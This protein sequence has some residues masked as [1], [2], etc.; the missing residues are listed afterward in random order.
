MA[1]LEQ[2][3]R[4]ALEPLLPRLIAVRGGAFCMGSERGRPDELPVHRVELRAFRVAELP[5]SNREYAAYLAATG[6][7]PP[8]FW[9]DPQFCAPEQ[10]VVGV[11]WAEASAYCRWLAAATG[12]PFRLPTEA[13]WE[14][15]A[16]A[17]REDALYPWGEE[18]PEFAPGV[19]LSDA[20]LT[21]TA[22]VG[23]GPANPLGIRDLGWNVHEWCSDW[24]SRDYY[25]ASPVFDPRG[26]ASG[27]RRA[28][29]GGAWRH[30]IKVNRTAARSAIPPGFRYN[31][32]GF[33]LFA[34]E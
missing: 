32:Y 23:L 31:D 10:P 12:I 6:V 20:P 14:Y 21:Q 3:P 8:R 29:R 17:G 26:P 16:L 4:S 9:S 18:M 7:A 24:Y 5:V 34:D 30:Q 15:A 13:E 22:P 33:R 28:S 2:E 27:E 11:T 25:A 19:P 1:G